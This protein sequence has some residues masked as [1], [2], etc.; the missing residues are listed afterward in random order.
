MIATIRAG[1]R[2]YV[3]KTIAPAEL[4]DAI[5]RVA[6]GDAVFSPR[7]AGFVLDAF[8][9]VAP[10]AGDP[11]LDLLTAREH[12][13]LRLIA[14]VH[15][16]GDRAGP[17]DLREDGRDPRLV[18][19]AEAAALDPPPARALGHRPPPRLSRLAAERPCAVRPFRGALSKWRMRYDV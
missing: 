7:L 5:A 2:G 18:G 13:V 19:V 16:Q 10:P 3:T 14:R 15:V 11:D 8:A 1:A 4:V 9:G 12:E 6:D 17:R